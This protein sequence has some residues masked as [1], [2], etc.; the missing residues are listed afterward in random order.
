MP[1]TNIRC[2]HCGRVGK[3]KRWA[4]SRI[5][6]CYDCGKMWEVDAND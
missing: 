3:V 5:C 2:P 6:R 1:I 4:G